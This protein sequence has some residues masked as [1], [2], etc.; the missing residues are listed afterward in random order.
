MTQGINIIKNAAQL[1]LSNPKQLATIAKLSVVARMPIGTNVFSRD[2]DVLIV[3]D[4]CRPDAIKEL[5]EEYDFLSSIVET[6]WSVG[7]NSPEWICNTFKSEYL[8]IIGK[9]SYISGNAWAERVLA[10][11]WSPTHWVAPNAPVNYQT[12]SEKRLRNIIHVW[13]YTSSAYEAVDFSHPSAVEVVDHAIKES[14]RYS[15]QRMIVHIME[16]HRPYIAMAEQEERTELRNYESDPWSYLRNDGSIETVWN[17]YLSEL[18]RGLDA[19]KI[20]L[21]NINANTV[22]I[23]ADHGE[24]FGEW[25]GYGHKVGSLNPVIRRVPWIETTAQD[26]QSR[27]ANIEYQMNESTAVEQLQALGYR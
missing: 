11:D 20:L 19:V 7:G 13:K 23:T 1:G 25:G 3:L 22:A 24:A 5:S 26:S 15:P 16:P 17:C 8:D 27:T 2:W 9:T 12:V 10:H 4:T 18:R 6:M 14:R 21:D